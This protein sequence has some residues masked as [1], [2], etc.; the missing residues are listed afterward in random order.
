MGTMGNQF[1]TALLL[2]LLTGL[3]LFV[4]YL[5]GGQSGLI[6]GFV[7]AILMNFV[8]FWFSDKI[9]LMMYRAKPITKKQA[10]NLYAIVEEV[11]QKAELPIPK[12]YIIPNM[13]PNAFATGR[14]PKHAAVAV[15]QGIVDLLT[16][17]ELKGVI[18]HEMAHVKNRDILI[19]TIAATI[20][21]VISFVAAM[22]RWSAIFGGG[23]DDDRGG[24]IISLL[25]IGIVTPIIAMLIQLAIS[26]SREYL[27]DESGANI[28]KTGKPLASALEKLE[29][30]SKKMPFRDANPATAHMFIVNP[31]SGKGMMALLST[32]PPI[33]ERVKRLRQMKF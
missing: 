11:A 20:A 30:G 25:V 13:T 12:I 14:G 18:A 23:R 9:V 33:P 28:I 16:H 24:N 32:H 5:L 26:R 22:A 3:L 17:D 6:I 31:L 4:G 15:T 2:G 29:M 1:R 19:G 8:S 27:A 10:P 7:I 21:G